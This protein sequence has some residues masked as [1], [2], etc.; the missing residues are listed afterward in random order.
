MKWEQF[1]MIEDIISNM[2][3]HLLVISKEDFY[4]WF[5]Q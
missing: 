4:V 2:T 3:H 1:D 5:Q